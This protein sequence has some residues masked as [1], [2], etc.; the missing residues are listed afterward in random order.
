MGLYYNK[1]LLILFLKKGSES[2]I[3]YDTSN[4]IKQISF[5]LELE[6]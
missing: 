2:A 5:L 3:E 6:S 1:L 4:Y